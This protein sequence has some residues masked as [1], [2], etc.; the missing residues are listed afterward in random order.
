MSLTSFSQNSHSRA[1]VRLTI[2]KVGLSKNE[3]DRGI[4]DACKEFRPTLKQ[5]HG[6]FNKA[7]PVESYIGTTERYS[8]CG[9]VRRYVQEG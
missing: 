8:D 9:S 4:V 1:I 7:Y 2:E 3:N 6:Y 5:V